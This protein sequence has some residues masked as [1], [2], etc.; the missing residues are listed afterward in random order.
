MSVFLRESSVGSSSSKNPSSLAMRCSE[1]AR[2]A[3][4]V[5]LSGSGSSSRTCSFSAATQ[6]GST[7]RILDQP[8]LDFYRGYQVREG[9]NE[10]RVTIDQSPAAFNYFRHGKTLVGCHHGN[11][12]KPDRL[13]G[14]MAADR[15]KDWGESEHRYWW[16]GHIHHQSVQDY[17]GCSVE[18]FPTLAAKDAWATSGGYR[19][20]RNMKCI[21]LHAEFGEVA[22]QTVNPQ[23]LE[24]A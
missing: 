17:P 6:A 9:A 11:T 1:S 19:S 14:V 2:L 12:C 20:A 10:P 5:M 7:D 24:A 21:V 23:M 15:A 8:L 18:S 16:I 22:R 3:P 13:P 4:L